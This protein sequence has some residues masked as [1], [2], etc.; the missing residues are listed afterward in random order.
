MRSLL[1]AA[2]A[3]LG[4]CAPWEKLGPKNIGDDVHG[5]GYAGTLAD[6][7]SPISNPSLIYTGGHNNGAS[8]GVLK[9]TD[10]GR[11]WVTACDG[12]WDTTIA[13]LLI[14]DTHGDHLLAGTP[15]GIYETRDAAETWSL[16]E[17]TTA[18]G[19]CRSLWN[20]TVEGEPHVIAGC[21]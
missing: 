20:G 17:Q 11:T 8:S 13:S 6:A 1:L 3:S 10:H 4:A 16:L 9:S 14:L 12:L 2:A 15:T 18:F 7:V 21:E 19:W 5:Q